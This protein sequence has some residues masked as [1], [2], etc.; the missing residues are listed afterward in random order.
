MYHVLISSK[1]SEKYAHPASSSSELRVTTV[2]SLL[3][4]LLLSVIG[5]FCAA[6]IGEFSCCRGGGG[7][8][9]GL[10]GACCVASFS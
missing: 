9:E 6:C 7:D 4:P 8:G 1:K 5:L 10:G 2:A 3:R